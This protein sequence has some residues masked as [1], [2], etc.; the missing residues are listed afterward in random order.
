MAGCLGVTCHGNSGRPCPSPETG[1]PG[2]VPGTR[3]SPVVGHSGRWRV[4]H[5]LVTGV[6]KGTHPPLVP[7]SAPCPGS[8]THSYA[9]PP[10]ARLTAAQPLPLRLLDSV[11]LVP[12][13]PQISL[14]QAEGR[15]LQA[16][17]HSTSPLLFCL[18]HLAR[19]EIPF[20]S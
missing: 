12:A 1:L 3:L 9:S 20:L 11:G 19:S 5:G 7:T 14:E 13:P 2:S 16:L 18:W 15:H 17:P 4:L 6:C 8:R 10:P